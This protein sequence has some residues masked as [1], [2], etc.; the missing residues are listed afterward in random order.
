MPTRRALP[1]TEKRVEHYLATVTHLR[2]A[3]AQHRHL[4]SFIGVGARLRH[5][6]EDAVRIEKQRIAPVRHRRGERDISVHVR[7]RIGVALE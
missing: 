3:E 2:A 5:A 1:V 7:N 6:M 4:V